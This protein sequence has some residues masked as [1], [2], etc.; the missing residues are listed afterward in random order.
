MERD[1]DIIVLD[2]GI[3]MGFLL[4]HQAVVDGQ[5]VRL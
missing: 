1:G 3:V 2:E 4:N 5:R